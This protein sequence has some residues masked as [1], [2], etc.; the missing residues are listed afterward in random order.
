MYENF[1]HMLLIM[2]SIKIL[3]V[4]G[5]IVIKLSELVSYPF[6]FVYK[7]KY[8]QFRINYS[9]FYADKNL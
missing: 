1:M 2:L 4:L 5:R 6:V 3:I 9:V 8:V 7:I